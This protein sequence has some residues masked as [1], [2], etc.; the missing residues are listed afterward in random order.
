M[1]NPASCLALLFTLLLPL[2]AP[3]ATITPLE[4][5]E[6]MR[7]TFAAMEDMS[8]DIV[9]EKHLAIMKKKLTMKGKVLF[10]KPDLFLMELAPPYAS[11]LLL[12]DGMVEQRMEG[13]REPTRI[14]LP[15]EYGLGKWM[16]R[17]SVP[18]TTLPEGMEIR[19]QLE[20]GLYTIDIAPAGKGQMKRISL[21]FARSGV[22]KRLV[23]EERSGDRAVITFKNIRKNT[24]LTRKD[25]KL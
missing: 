4:G 21:Q 25:F 24:G 7:S 10:K 22:M 11:R 3:A 13:E 17:L 12:Q 1:R 18:T 6:A 20:E 19:A 15:P 5:L 8:A 14:M 23:L 2:A 9:Q 16:E